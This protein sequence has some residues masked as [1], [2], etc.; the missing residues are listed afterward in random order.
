M[1]ARV[2]NIEAYRRW[3]NWVPL[4]DHDEEPTLEQFIASITED[5]PTEAMLAGTAFHKAIE[6]AEFGN[7]YELAA[8]GY[9]FMLRG[10]EVEL[11]PIREMR[12]YKKYGDLNVTGQVDGIHGRTVIDHKTTKRFDAERFLAGAQ[13]RF[14]LDIFDAD[15][16][17]WFVF[18]IKEM[19]AKTYD[20]SGPQVL[21]SYR[22]PGLHE[23]CAKLAA[24]YLAFA[25]QHLP[26]RF[27]RWAA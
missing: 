27:T 12:A 3:T 24:E 7:H 4:H 1:L 15:I 2:S 21:T 17:Q 26:E 14:Y 8:N 18:E 9:T 11:P 19:G 10:G 13:W 23:D 22:Y 25:R 6:H 5:R 16:F 20:V